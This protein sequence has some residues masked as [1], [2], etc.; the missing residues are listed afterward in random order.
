M[1]TRSAFLALTIVV[2]AVTHGTAE[3]TTVVQPA[4]PGAAPG[5]PDPADWREL[6]TRRT[7]CAT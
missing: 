6:P 1:P 3:P 4:S 5:V 2:L 7:N